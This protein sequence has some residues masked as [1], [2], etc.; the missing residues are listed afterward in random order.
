MADQRVY[1]GT[2]SQT[3][4]L[5][6]GRVRLAV[7]PGPGRIG[8]LSGRYIDVGPDRIVEMSAEDAQS[9][10]RNGWIKLAEWT[11]DQAA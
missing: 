10:I 4:T 2:F 5:F 11:E 8:T 6:V 3:L 1:A 7:P 9:F